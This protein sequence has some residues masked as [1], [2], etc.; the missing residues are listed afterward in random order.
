MFD[1]GLAMTCKN[2]AK[3]ID[4]SIYCVA[5]QIGGHTVILPFLVH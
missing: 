4:E 2:A 5:S 1:F 3:T